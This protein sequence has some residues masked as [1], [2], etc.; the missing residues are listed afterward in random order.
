MTDKQLAEQD[1]PNW[2]LPS[3]DA[4]DWA[5]EFVRLFGDK[6]DQIDEAL[7]LGW[8][9]NALM[10]GFDEHAHRNAAAISDAVAREREACAKVATDYAESVS[11]DRRDAAEYIA[12]AIRAWQP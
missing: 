4:R 7:M 1:H 8:F 5:A 2:P 11:Y 9:A 3:F 6:R 10:R 12:A